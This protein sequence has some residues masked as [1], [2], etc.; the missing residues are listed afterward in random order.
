[1]TGHLATSTSA[2]ENAF[3][4]SLAPTFGLTNLN[5]YLLGGYCT[6][7]G[8]TTGTDDD[9]WAW[10]TD[11]EWDWENWADGKPDDYWNSDPPE[12]KLNFF[13]NG[14]GIWNDCPN[15]KP[16]EWGTFFLGFI[17]EYEPSDPAPVPTPEPATFFL[18]GS[19]LAG[20]L[21]F[22]KK[23]KKSG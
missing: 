12:D 10:V 21:G 15:Q 22:R 16:E 6:D 5:Q 18:L 9:I 23:F 19:G 14:D 4:W 17:V 13:K 20:L 7:D 8:G 2:D 3:L 11:E 1:M